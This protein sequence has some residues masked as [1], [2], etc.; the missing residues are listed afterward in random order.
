MSLRFRIVF[1]SACA[2]LVVLV[3]LVFADH[4][5]GDA[6]RVRQEALQRY[7]G[8]V[9]SLV[10][11]R[12]A[13]ETGDVVTKAN[14]AT[15]DWLVD[16]VPEGAVVSMDEVVG[17]ELTVPAAAGMPL[18][19]LN[20]REEGDAIEVPSGHVAVSVPVTDKLGLSPSVRMGSHVAVF[21]AEEGAMELVSADAV[22]L[23]TAGSGTGSLSRGSISLS[24][25]P[26]EVAPVLVAATAGTLRVVVP[27][28]DV[29]GLGEGGVAAPSEVAAGGPGASGEVPAT[30][31]VSATSEVPA[32]E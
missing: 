22:V 16:L 12:D 11:A 4:V 29:V 14:T 27:A 31:G 17:R 28:D 30:G 23:S 1:S 18:T 9:V 32:T 19:S 8:E 26:G 2:A 10:V 5:R 6:E 25:S 24:V 21:R 13:L 15:R 7:G 3:F 20:F